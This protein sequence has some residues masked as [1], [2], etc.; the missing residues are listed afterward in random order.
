M[1][2]ATTRGAREVRGFSGEFGSSAVPP[3]GSGGSWGSIS[4]WAGISVTPKDAY[5]MPVVA[6][7]ISM[8]A[9]G[10]GALPMM[11]YRREQNDQ[12]SKATRAWQY[13]LLHDDPSQQGS[14]FWFYGGI[15]RSLLTCGNAYLLKFVDKASGRVTTL[16]LLQPSRIMLRVDRFTGAKQYFYT[17]E[18]GKRFGPWSE[19]QILHIVGETTEGAEEY[20][21]GVIQRHMQTLGAGIAQDEYKASYFRNGANPGLVIEKDGLA[22]EQQADE[23]LNRYKQRHQGVS[24]AFLPTLVP[25]GTKVT[26]I[27]QSLEDMA[28][29]ELQKFTVADVARM[30]SIP[31]ALLGQS[32]VTRPVLEDNQ[33][34][35][36][37][38]ALMPWMT[39][40]EQAMKAD[41]DLFGAG[42]LYPEFLADALMRPSTV[43]RYQAYLQGR[44]AGWL[45]VNDI[46]RFENM[47][48]IDGGDLYQAVPVGGTSDLMP[49]AASNGNAQSG[50]S[51][52]D[53]ADQN[54]AIAALRHDVFGAL[55][56]QSAQ[57]QNTLAFM[58]GAAS[59]GE[60]VAVH[61]AAPEIRQPDVYVTN[62]VKQ[63]R[64]PSVKVDAPITVHTPEA[65]VTVHVEP[66]AVQI[67]VT[68]EQPDVHVHNPEQPK[69]AIKIE[70]DKSGRPTRYTEE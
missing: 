66:A 52:S 59:R 35:F 20:G 30:F 46:R 57:L 28:F 44:Q 29:V 61:V 13:K 67:P 33:V 14:P 65:P 36:N 51:D 21:I 54:R 37:L 43:A 69:R 41:D 55:G 12:V 63:P 62:E 56:E 19:Q 70:R 22:S 3:P 60:P 31:P 32:D 10:I 53:A 25:T 45:S 7:A 15:V 4:S 42:A 38:H 47:P 8:I 11:V 26:K 27:S 18:N 24:N 5:G 23:W 1:I 50:T 34:L 39:R 6:Q 9:N 17:D 2:L 16:Q 64:A 49:G 68:V 58:R 40:V 48:P